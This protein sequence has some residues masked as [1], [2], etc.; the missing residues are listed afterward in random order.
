MFESHSGTG[1]GVRVLYL[2]PIKAQD[3][4][5]APNLRSPIVGVCALTEGQGDDFH[6][7]T[8]DIRSSDTPTKKHCQLTREPS[9]VLITSPVSLHLILTSRT[10]DIRR[11]SE[12]GI[13]DEIHSL[14]NHK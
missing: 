9:G 8:V 12:T 6:A 2:A 14:V 13:V 7:P 1:K 11:M 3:V 10:R 5:V 4:D